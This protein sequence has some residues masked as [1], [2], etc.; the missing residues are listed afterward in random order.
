M[1]GLKKYGCILFLILL[2]LSL[3]G[4]GKSSD[5][6]KTDTRAYTDSLGKELEIPKEPKKILALEN[7]GELS[8][9]EV[10]PA[11]TNDYFLNIF[12]EALKD[13]ASVGEFEPNLEAVIKLQPDLII[14]ADYIEPE[15]LEKLSKIAPTAVLKWNTSFAER[16]H[17]VAELI[18][19]EQAETAWIAGYEVKKKAVQENL[20]PLVAKGETALLLKGNA[21]GLFMFSPIWFPGIYDLMGFAA[22]DAIKP[23]LEKDPYFA[24]EAISMEALAEYKV[25]RIF[26]RVDAASYQELIDSPLRNTP[27]FKNGHIYLLDETWDN[28]DVKSLEIQTEKAVEVLKTNSAK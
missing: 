1:S 8:A 12:K 11:G 7:V 22:P 16:L 13:V 19:K 20:S 26:L 3:S 17:N 4:C 25:D 18:G 28:A 9:L 24:G 27:A 15:Q 14:V 10:T 5:D 21:K 23:L 6:V 2:S